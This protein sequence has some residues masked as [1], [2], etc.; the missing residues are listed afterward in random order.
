[1]SFLGEFL[2]NNLFSLF[3][4]GGIIY[5]LIS[6][7]MKIRQNWTKAELY[8]QVAE[9]LGVPYKTKDKAL[10]EELKTLIGH[11][12]SRN[13]SHALFFKSETGRPI[14]WV[15]YYYVDEDI[16]DDTR[17]TRERI[18]M[19]LPLKPEDRIPTFTLR[20]KMLGEKIFSIGLRRID[21][22][23]LGSFFNQNISIFASKQSERDVQHYFETH[24]GLVGF[25]VEHADYH[26]VSDGKWLVFFH[27]RNYILPTM[28]NVI[29]QLDKAKDLLQQI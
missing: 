8:P 1:M 9:Q 12:R 18:V 16:H 17:T 6:I 3:I 24:T 29:A 20:P 25:C 10:A 11:G 19:A 13:V 2:T 27:P 7:S 15:D 23:E 14:I 22:D 4:A 28:E 26:L 21:S 5:V